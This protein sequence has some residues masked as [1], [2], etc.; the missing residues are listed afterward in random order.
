MPES[1]SVKEAAAAEKERILAEKDEELNRLIEKKYAGNPAEKEE[2]LRQ[3]AQLN[4]LDDAEKKLAEEYRR[5]MIIPPPA[6][7]KP[8]PIARRIRLKLVLEKSKIR[9]G[10]SPRFRL[11][12]MNVGREAINYQE[13]SSS[14]FVKGAGLVDSHV[15]NIYITDPLGHRAIVMGT[16]RPSRK[17]SAKGNGMQFLPE[18]TSKADGEKWLAE[19]AALS[20]ASNHFQVKLMP[21]ETLHSIGD[22]DSPDGNF[23][24]LRMDDDYDAPG[25][26]QLQVVL[27]D[28]PEPLDK[29]YIEFS[30]RTGTPLDELQRTHS[31]R[32]KDALGPVSSNAAPYMVLQ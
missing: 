32:M 19:T 6:D 20:E 21:G 26:Y 15:M 24:T 30:T 16:N 29:E 7:F 4:A 11:E 13:Y 12:M 23:R 2:V 17:R 28:R 31:Q 8:E 5:T 3:V 25:R 14:L 27:D 10:E 1:H 9:R 22:D 18:N